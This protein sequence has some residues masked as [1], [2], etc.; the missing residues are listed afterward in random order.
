LAAR[1]S[2][3][4]IP[5]KEDWYAGM[6]VAFGNEEVSEAELEARAFIVAFVRANENKYFSAMPDTAE[7][8]GKAWPSPRSWDNT[9]AVWGHIQDRRVRREV[10]RGYVGDAAESAFD[11]WFSNLK[12][13]AYELVIAE[14]EKLAWNKF[15]TDEVYMIL[16]S[17]LD[18]VK[19]DNV[20][21]SAKVFEVANTIG[22]RTDVCAAL[23]IPL[24]ERCN[25]IMAE[26][27]KDNRKELFSLFKTY[28]PVLAKAGIK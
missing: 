10:M 20:P 16:S 15:K 24:I 12:L 6:R 26:T 22:N 4:Y 28:G 7:E 27:G 1:R 11:V 3:D 9:G 19:A 17:V 21:E 14:P 18:R 23:A 8:Q 2:V 13:P 25:E 5:D